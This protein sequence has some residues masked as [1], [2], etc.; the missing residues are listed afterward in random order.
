MNGTINNTNNENSSE[1][2]T[3]HKIID[4]MISN[5]YQYYMNDLNHEYVK[6]I[7]FYKKFQSEAISQQDIDYYINEIA[8]ITATV[9][10][11]NNAKSEID[12]LD[13]FVQLMI[14]YHD[15]ATKLKNKG[16][17]EP[18]KFI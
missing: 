15:H 11:F 18:F 16:I 2:T 17:N 13:A 4:H 7:L 10:I 3:I 12:K 1:N 5:G 9:H 14:N 8:N 6:M